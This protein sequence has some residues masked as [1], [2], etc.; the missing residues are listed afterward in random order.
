MPA[1]SHARGFYKE[2]KLYCCSRHAWLAIWLGYVVSMAL[3]AA[4]AMHKTIAIAT[5]AIDRLR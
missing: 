5:I 4:M 3:L 2:W 1:A